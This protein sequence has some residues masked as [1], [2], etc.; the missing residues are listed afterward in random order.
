M[1]GSTSARPATSDRRARGR[2]AARRCN[3]WKA[4]GIE[5]QHR[6]P[7]AL[8]HRQTIRPTAGGWRRLAATAKK[9]SHRVL[10]PAAIVQNKLTR[11][12]GTRSGDERYD[13][14]PVV[15]K[16]FHSDSMPSLVW[17]EESLEDL[18]RDGHR[19]WQ[20]TQNEIAPPPVLARSPV[21]TMQV[22]WPWQINGTPRCQSNWQ[23]RLARP[24]NNRRGRP[25]RRC[26]GAQHDEQVAWRSRND[27]R[28]QR[29]ID[30]ETRR[31]QNGA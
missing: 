29:Q 30:D 11:T 1:K 21:H 9:H 18:S 6:K 26:P 27:R 16:C 13:R 7:L 14:G 17:V 23:L 10:L 22:T 28:H 20:P 3:R 19:R 24:P 4:V 12:I 15:T 31:A 25:P 8:N 5:R 2:R